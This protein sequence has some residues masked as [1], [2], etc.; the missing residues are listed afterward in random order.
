MFKVLIKNTMNNLMEIYITLHF[1]MH[2]L[3]STFVLFI[4]I[5]TQIYWFKE[6][7]LPGKCFLVYYS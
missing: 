1:L 4:Q 6:L 3:V 2:R 7:L 5:C